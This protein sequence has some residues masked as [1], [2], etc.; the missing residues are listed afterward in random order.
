M[1][2]INRN[3]PSVDPLGM[4][5]ETIVTLERRAFDN[6][7]RNYSDQMADLGNS[8]LSSANIHVSV[9]NIFFGYVYMIMGDKI[10]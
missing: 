7:N 2:T 1:K 6:N 4:P 8:E 3:G 9:N 10:L 5:W